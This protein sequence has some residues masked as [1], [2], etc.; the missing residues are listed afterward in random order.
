MNS[1]TTPTRIVFMGTPEFAVPSLA[2]LWAAQA[3]HNWQI[4]AV[5]TQ[6]DR[7]AGRGNQL[8][9][10]AVKQYAVAQGM[11]VLQPERLRKTP[12]AIAILRA[13]APDLL[14]VAAYG[15]IL[16]K[17]VLEL[18]TFG[19]LNVHASLL[20]AYRGASPISAAILDGHAQ[21]GVTIMLMDEGLDTGPMLTQATL[22]I[23]PE[24]TTAS[25]TQRL[26]DLGAQLLVT[27]VPRWL[28][29]A[30]APTPQPE[31]SSTPTVARIEKEAGQIDWQQPAAQI[32][33]MTRAYTPWPTAYTTWQGDVFKIWRAAVLPGFAAPGVVV[34]TPQGI[35]VGTGVALLLLQEVQPA[36]KKRMELRSFL[37]GAPGFI[38]GQLGT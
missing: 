15:L 9:V 34:Q 4:V 1:I 8:A 32:E 25:L 6:P 37:N 24:D 2:A 7:P 23:Q 22:P 13:L 30:I 5:V 20:P 36:G 16:P 33:R 19:A 10:P 12:E 38:G 26:A 11:P 14:V 21:T 18:P 29:G 27:T 3:T 35:A 31:L 28:A 17:S